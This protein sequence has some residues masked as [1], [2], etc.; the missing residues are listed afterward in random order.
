MPTAMKKKKVV[1]SD[2]LFGEDA[3]E[4]NTDDLFGT[5]GAAAASKTAAAPAQSTVVKDA[6]GRLTPEARL[7]QFNELR[8]LVDSHIGKQPPA[9]LAKKPEQVRNTAWQHLF[10]LAAT[11]E[12]MET[13]VEMMPRWRDSR[14]EFTPRMVEA[15]IRTSHTQHRYP[16]LHDKWCHHRPM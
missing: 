9:R 7:A 4:E 8:E 1:D 14:R 6:K 16:T 10:S 11:K 3:F 5:G 15:F 2:D 12:Q 13:V